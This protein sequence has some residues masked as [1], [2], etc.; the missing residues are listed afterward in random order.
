MIRYYCAL[1][2][3]VIMM[4]IGTVCQKRVAISPDKSNNSHAH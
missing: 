3:A 4:E 2:G 1:L